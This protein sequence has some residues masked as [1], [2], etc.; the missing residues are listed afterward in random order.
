VGA[1][2]IWKNKKSFY[3]FKKKESKKLPFKLFKESFFILENFYEIFMNITVCLQSRQADK[4]CFSF[5]TADLV[6]GRNEK[7]FYKNLLF[8]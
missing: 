7:I 8:L 5:F 6:D 3:F 1:K 4:N 2:Q